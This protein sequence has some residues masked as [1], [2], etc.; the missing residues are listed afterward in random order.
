M[1]E[2]SPHT[3]RFYHPGGTIDT[4]PPPWRCFWVV[5]VKVL[6]QAGLYLVWSTVVQ[7]RSSFFG[8]R[9]SSRVVSP[10][11]IPQIS[12]LV[13]FTSS[14]A[15]HYRRTHTKSGDLRTQWQTNKA[16]RGEDVPYCSTSQHAE[17]LLPRRKCCSRGADV[18][19]MGTCLSTATAAQRLVW[20]EPR[21]TRISLSYDRSP[22]HHHL[23][24]SQTCV[25]IRDFSSEATEK[26]RT[27]H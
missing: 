13:V 15:V 18:L 2:I 1:L 20:R 5:G 24:Y 6:S 3:T 23:S 10:C 14:V 11:E 26:A 8:A 7:C 27:G 25:N 22:H 17:I 16:Q 4:P 9:F 21:H 19:K 12:D